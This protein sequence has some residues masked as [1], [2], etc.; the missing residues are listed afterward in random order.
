MTGEKKDVGV[1][2]NDGVTVG[3]DGGVTFEEDVGVA[4]DSC[5]TT[6]LGDELVV[7]RSRRKS[8][9]EEDGG[10]SFV[11]GKTVSSN[12]MCREMIM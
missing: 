12:T 2:G 3:D 5:G 10:S 9:E 8:K 7:T 4:E 1:T 6:T 11:K